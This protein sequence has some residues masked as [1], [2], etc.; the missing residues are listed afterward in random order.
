MPHPP[1]SAAGHPAVIQAEAHP[2]VQR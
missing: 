2:C 1:L